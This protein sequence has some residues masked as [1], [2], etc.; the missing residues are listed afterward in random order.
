MLAKLGHKVM[1]L[2]RVAVGPITIKGLTAGQF[3]PLTG[4]EVDLLRRVAAGQP[5]PM[6]WMTDRKPRREPERL[7]GPKAG[8]SAE[9][10]SGAG[11]A[12]W[13]RP[14][15]R[16]AGADPGPAQEPR[17]P[18]AR[19]RG[20]AP[21]RPGRPGE[22]RRPGRT[23][24]SER[25]AAGPP[26]G[27]WSRDRPAEGQPSRGSAHEIDRT[28]GIAPAPGSKA[29]PSRVRTAAR[30][31]PGTGLPV[32]TSN[33]PR[34]YDEGPTRPAG[35]A[36]RRPTD[37]VLDRPGP[38]STGPRCE[39]PPTIAA[40]GPWR[41]DHPPRDD[42]A[43]ARSRDRPS[44]GHRHGSRTGPGP[45]DRPK[46]RMKRSA[47]PDQEAG[48]SDGHRVDDRAPGRARARVRRSSPA[49]RPVH[50]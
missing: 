44:D 17:W 22:I 11:R 7:G 41:E 32:A 47:A 40:R 15:P 38:S 12:R 4:K 13:P 28:K 30:R 26:H 19:D 3:R 10:R 6:P 33:G 46:P 20:P 43:R 9:N 24:P 36:R 48:P 34:P 23:R 18:V 29:R 45:D 35:P 16:D 14:A 8:A 42:P 49:A 39:G 1:T 21:G 37:P 50:G 31:G 2:T 5:V 27:P 25:P